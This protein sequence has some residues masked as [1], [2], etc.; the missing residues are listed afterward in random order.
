[1]SV[2]GKKNADDSLLL[3]LAAGQ[4]VEDA[5]Q[6]ARV[7]ARTVY[8]RMADPEFAEKVREARSR[9][10]GQTLGRLIEANTKAADTLKALLDSKSDVV[11]LGAARSILELCLKVRQSTE[12]DA[13]LAEI[14]QHLASLKALKPKGAKR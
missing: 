11:R 5:A 14:E 12:T 3:A 2:P 1:M 7:S 10:L 9:L 4:S 6:S 8:R 13:R